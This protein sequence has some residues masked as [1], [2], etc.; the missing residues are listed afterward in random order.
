MRS[1]RRPRL[2]AEAPHHQQQLVRRAHPR[3]PAHGELRGGNAGHLRPVHQERDLRLADAH[4]QLDLYEEFVA[5]ALPD[6]H[7]LMLDYVQSPEFDE[8]L[9][10]TVRKTFPAHEHEQFVEHYRGL[11]RMWGEDQQNR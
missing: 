9:V 2:G 5:A 4:L 6:V 8:L 7:A 10:E 11:L 3:A 1:R